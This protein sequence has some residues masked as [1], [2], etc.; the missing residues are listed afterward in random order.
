MYND[1]ITTLNYISTT[2]E[3]MKGTVL[4]LKATASYFN[5]VIE[6]N[7]QAEK[8][9]NALV[10]RRVRGFAEY[11]QNTMLAEAKAAY[12]ESVKNAF[13]FNN[14]ETFLEYTVT[15]NTPKY[16]SFYLDEYSYTGGAH[17][18]TLRESHTLDARTGKAMPLSVFFEECKNYKNVILHLIEEQANA[19]YAANPGIYFEDYRTLIAEYFNEDNFYLTDKGIAIYYQQYQIAPYSTGIVVFEIPYSYTKN[20]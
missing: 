1:K 15:L 20:C 17:G 10:D 14:Y 7:R 3:F 19:N 12:T 18:N 16:L 6:D 9:I 13:N 5:A 4:L 2:K 11:A 8:Y